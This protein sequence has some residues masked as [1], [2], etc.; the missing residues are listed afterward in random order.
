ME[1]I[2]QQ[3]VRVRIEDD[4]HGIYVGPEAIR[5]IRRDAN[6]QADAALFDA[7][8]LWQNLDVAEAGIDEIK[9]MQLK[10]GL[11]SEALTTLLY[12]APLP[13]PDDE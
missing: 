2:D 3:E 4:T 13:D 10:I 12:L 1:S 11:V 8:G 6:E 5:A 7:W 9:E